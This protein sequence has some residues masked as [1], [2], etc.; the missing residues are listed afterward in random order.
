MRRFALAWA[1]SCAS[2]IAG[3]AGATDFY[4]HNTL[5]LSN[6]N[7]FPTPLFDNNSVYGTNPSAITTDGTSLW[8]AGFNG[9]TSVGSVSGI[10]RID[11]PWSSPTAT[12]IASQATP[13]SRGY[14]GLD[15]DPVA[16][17][18]VAAFDN[19][20]ASA[21]GLTGWNIGT[22]ANMWAK[23]ARGGS[24]VGYD[25]GFGG[26]DQ[27]MA[28]STFGSGRR[29][30]L[31]S[32]TGADI[33]TTSTGMIINGAGTG[34]FW[35]DMDFAPNGDMWL[36]EGNQVI[37]ATR[38]GGNSVTGTAVMVAGLTD[39]DF[40]NGQNIEY[41]TIPGGDLVIFNDRPSTGFGQL[42]STNVRVINPD[43]SAASSQFFDDMGGAL[44]AGFGLGSGYFTFA[45][46]AA[47]Q[48]LI[49]LDFNNRLVYQFKTEPIPEPASLA[50]LTIGALALLR[51]R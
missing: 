35:R 33:Y 51:R 17:A 15:I 19:G 50:L 47:N 23:N 4:L 31:N 36:R 30:L 42:W 41:L 8:I 39:A 5:D 49:A 44:P 25:P 22:N 40:V 3:T 12:N 26:V 14:S 24:G 38:N 28:W 37:R 27:G 46:D 18:V 20:A 34:T 11:A 45:W 6:S 16:G 21:N 29:A 2:L 1:L 10:V 9:G 43:G 7:F 13:G 48:A 32:S